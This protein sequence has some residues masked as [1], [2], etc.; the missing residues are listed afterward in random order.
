MKMCSIASGSS[1]NCIF[2]GTEQA[3]FLVDAVISRK[4]TLQGVEALDRS[5]EAQDAIFV[6]Q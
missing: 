2:V 4:R 6:P 3:S 5:M 1:G